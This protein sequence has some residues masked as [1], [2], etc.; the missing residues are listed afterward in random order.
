MNDNNN[1]DGFTNRATWIVNLAYEAIFTEL[2]EGQEWDDM[3][4]LADVMEDQVNNLEYDT[5]DVNTIVKDA[6]GEYLEKVNWEEIAQRYINSISEKDR[7]KIV[8]IVDSLSK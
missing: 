5:L 3:E 6:V 4:C 7:S 1:Y 2:A 8:Q